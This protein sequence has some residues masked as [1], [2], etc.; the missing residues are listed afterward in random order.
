M[1]ISIRKILSVFFTALIIV[2]L[3]TVIQSSAKSAAG[4]VTVSFEDFGV[5][6]KKDISDGTVDF[7]KPMGVIVP[8]TK[9]EY[10]KGE[11]IADVTLRLIKKL[12]MT[13]TSDGD[14]SSS[15]Y[16]SSIGNFEN[17]NYGH[18]SS[19][20]EFD[21][22]PT[23]GWM[24]MHNNKFISTSASQVTAD[25]GDYVCWKYSCSLGADIGCD[26]SNMSA[27]FSGFKITPASAAMTPAFSK[28]VK[29]YQI[30]VP[31]GT[32]SIK[33]E[34]Q[35]ENYWSDVT[36]KVGSKA[37]KFRSD[38]PVADGTKIVVESQFI[39]MVGQSATD[40]DKVT[41]TVKINKSSLNMNKES[42]TLNYKKSETLS[43]DYSGFGKVRWTSSDTKVAVV[44]EN[45]KVTATGRGKAVITAAD[46]DGNTA[47]CQVTVKYSFIQWVIVIVLFG[48]IWY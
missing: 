2:S 48:W 24:V 26:W 19:F 40:K 21:A 5:R 38:I 36:Y 12:G 15:F 25:D 9:V 28:S 39:P 44:D 33:L 10:Y 7:V 29:N 43:T 1:K 31:S 32:K 27:K 4:Y 13:T 17:K 11:N 41:F 45:G 23:S 18:V 22:G 6:Q 35:N 37:Y 20:G 47:E 14:T 3:F 42:I 16:L 8:E 46:F 30:N 34:A